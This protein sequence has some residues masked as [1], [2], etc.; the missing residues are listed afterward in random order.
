MSYTKEKRRNY[1][2]T[3]R[4]KIRQELILYLGG[5]CV[6]CQAT[7]QLEFDHKDPKTKS[8]TIASGLDKPKDVLLAEVNK[9]QLLCK[10]CHL[11]KTISESSTIHANPWNKGIQVQK[12]R[13]GKS[14]GYCI[15]R[16]RCEKCVNWNKQRKRR[17]ANGEARGL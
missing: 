8:F 3:R 17:Y 6:V 11:K 4:N 15:D 10:N 2:N 14:S 7:D 5:S 1:Q 16:C 12:D 13:H 9:C